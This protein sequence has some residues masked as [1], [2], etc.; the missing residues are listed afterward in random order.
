L[1]SATETVDPKLFTEEMF[2]DPKIVG[3]DDFLVK[4]KRGSP[5]VMPTERFI[6]L[7]G[8][9]RRGAVVNQG[10]NTRLKAR[11]LVCEP[12][13]D[14][15]DYYGDVVIFDPR[16][17]IPQPKTVTALPV[18]AFRGEYGSLFSCG[19]EM[20]AAKVQTLM[21]VNDIS[22]IPV[23]SNDKK[24]VYGVVTWRSIAQ[25]RG[26]LQ[27]ASAKDIQGPAGHVAS[28]SDDF[29]EHVRTIIAQ[30][31]LFY[32]SPEGKVDGIVT[33]SDLAQAFDST[34]GIYI[35]LQEIETR[36]RILL[37]R[38]PIPKLQ[39][40]LEPSHRNST[41]FRGATDMSFGEYIHALEDADIWRA[42][43]ITLDQ[44]ICLK[45]LSEVKAVRNG[46]MHF[47]AGLG[48]A[49]EPESID[50][51]CVTSALRILR[52]TPIN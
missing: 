13:I 47:S 5:W 51:Q 4:V 17:K 38:S 52:A 40:H 21:V 12:E 49:L 22:Q 7:Y 14:N 3:L 11:G 41:N 50:R 37:D 1:T 42:C 31:Y 26:D 32:R 46:V 48:D 10:I 39:A 6:R 24:T 16:D 30:E 20:P 8:N 27:S 35:Q 29:L 36:L 45:V 19:P 25:F 2:Q 43:G 33:A 44:T 23:L 34:A 28:S 18:S 15:A 9:T